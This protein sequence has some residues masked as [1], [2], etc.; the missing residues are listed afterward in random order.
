MKISIITATYNSAT[1]ITQCIDSVNEQT[2]PNIEHIIIDGASK[3]N[4]LE[5]IKSMPNRITNVISEPDHGIYDAMNKG[6]HLATGD[7]IGTLNSDDVYSNNKIL[8]KI[9]AIFSQ[10]SEIECLY[11]NLV[12]INEGHKTVRK[13]V[14]R[15]FQ[16]GLFEKSWSPAH[17]TFY[18]RREVFSKY[19]FY[20]TNY[21]I[22]ADVEFMFRVLEL[23]GIKSYFLD[24]TIVKMTIGGVSNRGL[25]ST[26]TIIGELQRAFRENDRKLNLPKY[27]FFKGLKI[28]EYLFKK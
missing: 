27:L 14:S 22:A 15:K 8:S 2:Y 13:W 18:C 24:E 11:G 3:D 19:G 7:I 23:H 21:K 4:T 16:P 25:K 12:Y 5:I 1:T 28:K 6:I 10:N 20:K 26:I 9:A 17:P